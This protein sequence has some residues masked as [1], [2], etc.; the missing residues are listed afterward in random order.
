MPRLW[1][2]VEVVDLRTSPARVPHKTTITKTKAAIGTRIATI[3]R[4]VAGKAAII[5]ITTFIIHVV[6][7]HIITTTIST[8]TIIT[9]I[10]MAERKVTEIIVTK[11][12]IMV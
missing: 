3:S 7:V 8:I 5:I 6:V 10:I 4:T 12:T 11:I 2:P 9:T 1:A